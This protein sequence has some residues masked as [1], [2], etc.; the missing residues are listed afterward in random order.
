[1]GPTLVTR[2]LKNAST[3]CF[4]LYSPISWRDNYA[5]AHPG[6]LKIVQKYVLVS[7]IRFIISRLINTS[8]VE[9]IAKN[10]NVTMAQIATAWS[11]TKVTAPIVGT[12][13]LKNLEELAG[14]LSQASAWYIV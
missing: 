10:H 5:Q 12:T 7:L 2:V 11:L 4:M 14:T 9:E 1:M 6:N 13:S 8:R 3:D